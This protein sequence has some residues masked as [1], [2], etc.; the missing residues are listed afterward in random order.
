MSVSLIITTYNR[1]DALFLVLK[2]VKIQTILPDEIIISKTVAEWK[3]TKLP[4]IEKK[5]CIFGIYGEPAFRVKPNKKQTVTKV[6][7]W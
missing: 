7:R 5:P 1:P 3:R 6:K 2:S 4:D